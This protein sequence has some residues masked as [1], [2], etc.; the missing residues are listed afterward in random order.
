MVV[1]IDMNTPCEKALRTLIASN[2]L[3]DVASPAN[4]LAIINTTIMSIKTVFLFIL[5][6]KGVKIGAPTVT[7]IAYK[8]T[9]SPANGIVT[10]KA[11]LINGSNPTLINSVEPIAKAEIASDISA[12]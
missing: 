9:V 10:S 1:A 6:V 8:D 4:T 7:P 3:N 12:S 2:K 11:S 5:F